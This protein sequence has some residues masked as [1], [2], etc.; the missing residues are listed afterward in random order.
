MVRTQSCCWNRS[1]TRLLIEPT[2]SVKSIGASSDDEQ[3]NRAESA[4]C[5]HPALPTEAENVHTLIVG[6]PPEDLRSPVA[7][8][9][10]NIESVNV[11]STGSIRGMNPVPDCG[12][13]LRVLGLLVQYC[14]CTSFCVIAKMNCQCYFKPGRFHITVSHHS[15]R[16]IYPVLRR[17]RLTSGASMQL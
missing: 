5:L 8:S 1:N 7:K 15:L 4:Q 12:C 9:K 11:G 17:V 2:T 3:L 10:S 16:P 6:L 14:G 13:S